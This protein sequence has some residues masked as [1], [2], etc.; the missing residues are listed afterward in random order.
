MVL[1]GFD[2]LPTV[3]R[4]NYYTWEG[5]QYIV[6]IV[7]FVLNCNFVNPQLIYKIN[8]YAFKVLKVLGMFNCSIHAISYILYQRQ[9]LELL[10]F[11]PQ[12]QSRETQID[13]TIP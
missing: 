5:S 4:L 1:S 8:M 2:C 3:D 13:W 9:A 12:C 11:L 6:G 7:Q 10:T